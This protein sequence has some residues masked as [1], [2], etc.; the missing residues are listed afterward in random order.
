MRI[1]VSKCSNCT[2]KAFCIHYLEFDFCHYD[3]NPE[4]FLIKKSDVALQIL[5][6]LKEEMDTIGI[7]NL[8]NNKKRIELMKELFDYYQ[9]DA[10]EVFEEL[11][12]EAKSE[13]FDEED[14]E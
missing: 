3:K 12:N 10:K 13:Q 9:E 6:K 11:K 7:V 5:K 4:S 8:S 2:R 1:K 14:S